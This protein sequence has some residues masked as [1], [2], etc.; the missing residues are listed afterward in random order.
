MSRKA[1][2]RWEQKDGWKV[3]W[4]QPDDKHTRAFCYFC[5]RN[6]ERVVAQYK[7]A[8]KLDIAVKEPNKYL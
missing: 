7:T 6:A 4:D 2:K 1:F 8:G 5:K 3:W